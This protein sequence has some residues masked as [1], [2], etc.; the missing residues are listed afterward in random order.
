[1]RNPHFEV[2]SADARPDGYADEIHLRLSED[3]A[4]QVAAVERGRADVMLGPPGGRLKGSSRS[5][6]DGFTATPCRGRTTCS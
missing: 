2:W 1:V 3:V 6:R 5:I 4:A